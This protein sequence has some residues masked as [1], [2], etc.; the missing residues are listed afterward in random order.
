MTENTNTTT[1]TATTKGPKIQ[2]ETAR[3][4]NYLPSEPRANKRKNSN[5]VINFNTNYRP[6]NRDEIEDM[7]PKYMDILDNLLQENDFVNLKGGTQVIDG[8]PR[9]TTPRAITEEEWEDHIFRIKV[10]SQPEV[11]SNI[12][13]G[14]RF[15]IHTSIYFLH[16][17]R[18]RL[19][20]KF[21]QAVFNERLGAAGLRLIQ[22]T[23]IEATKVPGEYYAEKGNY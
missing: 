13:R 18:L 2:I 7:V 9:T 17:L 1:T 16:D 14:A 12:Q 11:G 22:Y 19:D 4:I 15:H 5:F 10:S 3:A 20:G 23:H 6:R 21:F 8:D